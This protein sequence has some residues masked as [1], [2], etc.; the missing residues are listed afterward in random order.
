MNNLKEKYG[1]WA[2][3][4]GATSGIGKCF[5]ETLAK[6]GFHL[7]L[8]ARNE[9]KLEQLSKELGAIYSI[10]C[11]VIVTDLTKE[12]S[13][14]DIIQNTSTIQVGLL[15]NNAG[16]TF[17]GNF[18][19]YSKDSQAD[20][21]KINSFIP[22][23][24]SYEFAKRMTENKKGGI[25]N[26][27]SVSGMMPLPGWA[28]YAAS[29]AFLLSLSQSL[30]FEL[31]PKGI[32]VLALCPGATKTNFHETA[33]VN[34]SGLKP[35]EVVHSGLK[36]LGKRPSVIVGKSNAF[37]VSVMQ[38]LPTKLKIRTGAMAV[39]KMS[40]ENPIRQSPVGLTPSPK[41]KES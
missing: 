11:Q 20:I 29:K 28:S 17:T 31:K 16:Y 25:I 27:C 36:Y 22:M 32:D 2:L 26:V 4:T 21:V 40:G 8:V 34:S 30:W 13:V 38:F 39:Q 3:I 33:Q 6:K 37:M 7:V 41:G 9:E 23:L 10:Q 18:L 35:E 15:I 12:T 19:E 5:A 24:L 1:D 14:H